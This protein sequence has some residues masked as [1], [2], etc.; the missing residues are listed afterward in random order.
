MTIT[1]SKM[2]PLGTAAPDFLLPDMVSGKSL[3]LQNLRSPKGTVIMFIC[4]HCPFVKQAKPEILRLVRKYQPRGINF[5]AIN[6]DNPD[7]HSEDTPEKMA[8]V[9]KADGFT[10]PYLVDETQEIARAY[11]ATCCP[12]F[13]LFD[14]TLKCVYRGQLSDHPPSNKG[15]SHSTASSLWIALDCLLA[16]N[17]IPSDQKPSMGC[18]IKWKH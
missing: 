14:H 7:V 11:Q 12:D 3:S 17:P 15:N 18:D 13:F 2:I 8:K 16:G 10:F 9:A 6:S 4:N 1:L 5:V